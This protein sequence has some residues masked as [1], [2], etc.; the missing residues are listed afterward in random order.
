MSL[1]VIVEDVIREYMDK[2]TADAM[3]SLGTWEN[4]SQ[5]ARDTYRY[6]SGRSLDDYGKRMKGTHNHSWLIHI[7][8]PEI[9]QKIMREGFKSSLKDLN[10]RATQDIEKAEEM[11]ENGLCFACDLLR[12]NMWQQIIQQ[13]K[14][15]GDDWC[16]VIFKG[17]GFDAFTS[18]GD[19]DEVVFSAPSAHDICLLLPMT[20]EEEQHYLKYNPTEYWFGGVKLIGKNGKVLFKGDIEDLFGSHYNNETTRV[21]SKGKTWLDNNHTQYRNNFARRR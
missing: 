5:L 13:A 19:F 7:T 4:P 1:N 12:D 2:M 6:A 14:D 15:Y 18:F 17:S 10:F 16:G 8:T 20:E 11:T 21:T 3:R 9:G